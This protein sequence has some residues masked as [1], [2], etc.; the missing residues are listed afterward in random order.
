MTNKR[1]EIRD[2]STVLSGQGNNSSGAPH[3]TGGL[4]EAGP[5]SLGGNR[6]HVL[7]SFENGK[8][9]EYKAGIGAGRLD[10]VG[11]L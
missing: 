4:V 9:A 1:F 5:T 10:F 11:W 8:T 2:G 6:L 7:V 3:V